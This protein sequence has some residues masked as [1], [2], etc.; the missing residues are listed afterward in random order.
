MILKKDLYIHFLL[1]FTKACPRSFQ[2]FR[3]DKINIAN[4]RMTRYGIEFHYPTSKL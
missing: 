3:I 1:L 4:N 2:L